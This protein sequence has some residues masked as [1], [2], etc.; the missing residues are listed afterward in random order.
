MQ[1]SGKAGDGGGG[2]GRSWGVRGGGDDSK[3]KD[4]TD[5][6]TGQVLTLGTAQSWGFRGRKELTPVNTSV[7]L[8]LCGLFT[9]CRC[10][11]H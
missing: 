7:C 1:Q 10:A 3:E 11:D 2:A 9:H 5:V 8:V 6:N 4:Y